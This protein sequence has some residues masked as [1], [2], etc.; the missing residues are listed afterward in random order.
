MER[1][2]DLRENWLIFWGF[3]G[4][5][6]LILMILGA[7]EKYSLQYFQGSREHTLPGGLS[8]RFLPEETLGP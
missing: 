8:L 7:K 5:A 6:E 3:W 1:K 2:I 4:E